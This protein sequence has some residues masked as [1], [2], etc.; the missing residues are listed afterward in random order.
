MGTYHQ[1]VLRDG[2]GEFVARVDPGDY[3][4]SLKV[5]RAGGRF[6]TTVLPAV[7]AAASAHLGCELSPVWIDDMSGDGW[8]SVPSGDPLPSVPWDGPASLWE[9]PDLPFVVPV[10]GDDVFNREEVS[11]LQ[12]FFRGGH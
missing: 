5:E 11:A 10:D 9:E 7:I 12:V 8:D 1:V 6:D 2:A 3:G 4:Y